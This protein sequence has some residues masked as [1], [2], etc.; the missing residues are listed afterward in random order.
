MN[1]YCLLWDIDGTLLNTHGAGVK[2]LEVAIYEVLGIQV[3][4]E[5]G[6]YSGFT[7]Y[8]IIAD[9]TGED[10]KCESNSVKFDKILR[11]YTLGLKAAL[12]LSPALPIGSIKET[13]KK[14]A[15]TSNLKS[16][17]GTGNFEPGALVKL[18]SVGLNSYFH[19]ES[20]FGATNVRRRRVEIIKY[21][22]ENLNKK[23]IPI[24]VGDAP[25]DITA[26]RE[27][28]LNIIATPTGHHSFEDLNALVPG[29]VLKKDWDLDDLMCKVEKV[30]KSS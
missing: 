19:Q 20:I 6:K 29:M 21:A 17:V 9:L 27:N 30:T 3:A 12:D 16:F 14:L 5:R 13:L 1:E 11:R 28:G 23:Y 10:V 26:A 4:L 7:D 18:E 24:V 22:T 2:P 15:R 25:A 8:E